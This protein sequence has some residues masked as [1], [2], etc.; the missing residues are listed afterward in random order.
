M[1]REIERKFLVRSD[2]YKKAAAS[3]LIRQGYICRDP[4]RVVRVR[5]YGEESFVTIKGKPDG[6]ARPEYEYS[7]PVTDATELLD[8]L[9]VKP[10]IEKVRHEL[11]FAG[12][13]WEIDE[14]LGDNEGLVVA[15]IELDDEKTAFENPDWVGEE[16]T[17]DPRY[18]N[19]NL[20]ERPFK[21]WK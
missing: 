1:A 18:L 21:E 12:M 5:I 19:S 6:L 4:E 20:V 13:I 14:F 9:C 17:N 8:R 7:I 10:L 11:F 3:H 2:E 16:V 15:E